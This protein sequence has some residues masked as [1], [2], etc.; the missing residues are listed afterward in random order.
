MF[1]TLWETCNNDSSI[2]DVLLAFRQ[3]IIAL[4]E[5]DLICAFNVLYALYKPSNFVD[6]RC[7]PYL[8]VLWDFDEVTILEDFACFLDNYDATKIVMRPLIHL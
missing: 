7:H 3:D 8:A 6:Q 2:C 5:L 1:L 4:D